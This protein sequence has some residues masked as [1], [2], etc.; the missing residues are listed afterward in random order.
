MCVTMLDC[1]E[2]FITVYVCLVLTFYIVI[3]SENLSHFP[4]STVSAIFIT[5]VFCVKH[6]ILRSDF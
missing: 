5:R 4:F 6:Q 1:I 2:L 3:K